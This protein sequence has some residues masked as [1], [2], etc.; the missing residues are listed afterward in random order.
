MKF[1]C[2]LQSSLE[3]LTKK[4]LDMEQE[5]LKAQEC[6]HDTLDKLQDVESKYLQLRQNLHKYYIVTGK[7]LFTRFMIME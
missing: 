2:F 5:L 6:S 4:N 3:S 7:T 1:W